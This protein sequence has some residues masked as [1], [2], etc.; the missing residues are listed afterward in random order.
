MS[1]LEAALA[2]G[3]AAA[4]ELM[5]ETITITRPGVPVFDWDTG[6][7][8]PGPVTTIYPTAGAGR[9]R[10]KPEKS[11]GREAEAGE[12]L[13]VLRRFTVSLPW[14]APMPVRPKPGD[15]GD[16]STSPD[17][18]MVGLRLWVTGVEYSSTATAW[19]ISMEDRS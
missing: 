9:A 10:V 2:A 6:T 13:V 7:E 17:A 14:S 4:E 12:Q 8:T 15:V 18:R 5:R 19:R 3:R 16:V 11:E 1:E